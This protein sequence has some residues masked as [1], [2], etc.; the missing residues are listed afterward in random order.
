MLPKMKTIQKIHKL[1]L[2]VI[3]E[4]I[5]DNL[6]KDRS[7]LLEEQLIEKIGLDNLTNITS[8]ANPPILRGSDNGFY[9]K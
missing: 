6:T 5:Y 7:R 9:Q 8:N 2:E 3:V 1:G 4:I